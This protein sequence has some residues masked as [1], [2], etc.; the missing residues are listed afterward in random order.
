MTN[1]QIINDHKNLFISSADKALQ[2]RNKQLRRHRFFIKHEPKFSFIRYRTDHVELFWRSFHSLNWRFSFRGI[3][4]PIDII[5]SQAGFISPMDFCVLGMRLGGDGWI[6]L[7]KPDPYTFIISFIG[8]TQWLL[9]CETPFFQISTYGN[10]CHLYLKLLLQQQ[11]NRLPSPQSKRQ[12][13]L[14]RTMVCQAFTNGLFVRVVKFSTIIF[15]PEKKVKKSL[16]EEEKQTKMD[17]PRLH[18]QNHDIFLKK[19]RA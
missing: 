12:F 14:I 18:L 1:S 11:L 5:A 17:S 3:A 6:F 2:K 13:Q 19:E 7:F 4:A 15:H 8:S 9:R 16:S 10:K